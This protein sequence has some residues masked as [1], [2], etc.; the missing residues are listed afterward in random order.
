MHHTAYGLWA[1]HHTAYGLWA[2]HHTAYG[3]VIEFRQQG[4]PNIASHGLGSN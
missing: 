2:M 3:L 1:M 4:A